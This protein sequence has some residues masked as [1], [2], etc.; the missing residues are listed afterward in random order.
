ME[1]NFMFSV[2]V[3]ID[4]C[5]SEI[6]HKIKDEMRFADLYD[7]LAEQFPQGKVDQLKDFIKSMGG[8][9]SWILLI[10]RK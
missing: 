2:F 4:C 10:Y 8:F 3:Y 9:L 6:Y 7:E 5:V 1:S